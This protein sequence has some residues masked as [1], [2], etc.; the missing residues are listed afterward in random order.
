M[1]LNLLEDLQEPRAQGGW[2]QHS[3]PTDSPQV[4]LRVIDGPQSQPR[5]LQPGLDDFQWT[6]E[7]STDRAPAPA[8]QDT[9]GQSETNS[10]A[11]ESQL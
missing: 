7:D 8:R 6:R 1:G 4:N 5:G 9:A 11:A 3:G 2:P 10:A